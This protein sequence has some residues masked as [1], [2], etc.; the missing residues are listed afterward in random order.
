M[1]DGAP[2]HC[3]ACKSTELEQGFVQTEVPQNNGLGRWISG[4][5]KASL[6]STSPKGMKQRAQG[7]VV[8]YRCRRCSHLEQFVILEGLPNL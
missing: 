6:F 8:S 4:V 2:L 7:R 5:Y 1:E 3:T